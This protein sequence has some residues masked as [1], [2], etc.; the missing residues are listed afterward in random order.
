[1]AINWGLHTIWQTRRCHHSTTSTSHN[2]RRTSDIKQQKIKPNTVTNSVL[3]NINK[4]IDQYINIQG[5]KKT[6]RINR[7]PGSSN[8][9]AATSREDNGFPCT[10]LKL[11]RIFNG[12]DSQK[13][14]RS[15]SSMRCIQ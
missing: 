7:K 13:M 10:L 6:K 11:H 8:K 1:M 14:A 2:D 12:L 3:V 5:P 9:Y 15:L 4:Q